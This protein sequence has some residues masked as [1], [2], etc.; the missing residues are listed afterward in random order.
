MYVPNW[1]FF[2]LVENRLPAKTPVWAQTMI[3]F[4]FANRWAIC[5][6]TAPLLDQ[7]TL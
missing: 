1:V 2:A 7:A 3:Y 6:A 4:F 5:G